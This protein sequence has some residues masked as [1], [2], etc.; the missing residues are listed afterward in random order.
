MVNPVNALR[1]LID[2]DSSLAFTKGTDLFTGPLRPIA[3]SKLPV[4]ALFVLG[5]P[6]V[7]PLRVMGEVNEIRTL[8]VELILRYN[9][10]NPG[11]LKAIDI[12][13]CLLGQTPTGF[14]D[15]YTIQSEPLHSGPD[16]ANYHKFN[17]VYMMVYEQAAA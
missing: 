4:N 1:D 13:N 10:Y 11:R 15:T 17:I 9:E 3:D 6:S 8:G 14:L 12:M 5:R 7:I 2:G 16:N